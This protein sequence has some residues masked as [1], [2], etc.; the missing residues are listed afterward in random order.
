MSSFTPRAWKSQPDGVREAPAGKF[1]SRRL[2]KP[3]NLPIA[4]TSFVG[5]ERDVADVKTLLERHALVTL[6][7]S[8]GVSKTRLALTV[9][10][11]L[12]DPYPDGVWFVD[13]A[14][15]SDPE[16]VSSDATRTNGVMGLRQAHGYAARDAKPRRDCDARSGK[17]GVVRRSG[18]RG[19]NESN[20]APTPLSKSRTLREV[21]KAS[22][23]L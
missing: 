19:S 22:L 11:A 7:G 14:P 1:Q 20:A 8:G 10:T 2:D 15:I 17:R 16:L 4:R 9:G 12:L 18:R 13:L 3:N 21:T 6:V 23:R 5:R